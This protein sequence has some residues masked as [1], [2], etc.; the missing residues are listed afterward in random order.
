MVADEGL[1]LSARQLADEDKR[2]RKQAREIRKQGAPSGKV[3]L[4]AVLERFDLRS[5]AGEIVE[6]RPTLAIDFAPGPGK[7][8]IKGHNVLRALSGRLW[9]GEETRAIMRVRMRNGASIKFGLGLGASLSDVELSL[10]FQ[11]VDGVWLPRTAEAYVTG[12]LLL[13]KRFRQH[14]VASCENC[15]RFRVSSAEQLRPKS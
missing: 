3:K 8:D 9:V 11:E 14:T 5:V 13:L 1:P 2:V 12:K 6:A 7:G 10:D 4:S 15:W